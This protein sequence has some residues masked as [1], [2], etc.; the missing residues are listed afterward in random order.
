MMKTAKV[1]F[2]LIELLVVIAIIAILAAMLMPALSK[3]REAAKAS[4]CVANQK[5]CVLAMIQYAN[6]HRGLFVLRDAIEPRCTRCPDKHVFYPW[7]D[8][9]ACL[10]YIGADSKM[11]TCPSISA[12]VR[13]VPGEGNYFWTYSTFSGSWGSAFGA[14]DSYSPYNDLRVLVRAGTSGGTDS[15]RHLDTKRVLNAAECFYTLDTWHTTYSKMHYGA[16]TTYSYFSTRHN[17]RANAG[18]ID[19]HVAAYDPIEFF[20]MMR[21]NPEDFKPQ[22]TWRYSVGGDTAAWRSYTF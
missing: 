8:F 10:G 5:Q 12:T 16:S 11:L 7:G 1:C 15:A 22:G 18:F 21:R 17:G 20:S 3:A 19:G 13:D 6:D 4:S 9:I 2:T 14:Q